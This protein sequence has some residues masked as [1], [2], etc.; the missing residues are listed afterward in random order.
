V[1]V[2]SKPV[3]QMKQQHDWLLRLTKGKGAVIIALCAA[4]E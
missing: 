4:V 1:N 3:S 2:G